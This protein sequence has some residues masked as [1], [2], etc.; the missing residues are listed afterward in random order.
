M[1]LTLGAM[2]QAIMEQLV[3]EINICNDHSTGEQ[4][5]SYYDWVKD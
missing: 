2:L 1:P 3:G 5:V 4:I